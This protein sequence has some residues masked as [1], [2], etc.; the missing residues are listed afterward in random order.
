M[1]LAGVSTQAARAGQ[2]FRIAI[3][4]GVLMKAKVIHLSIG[5]S[6][7]LGIGL[8]TFGLRAQSAIAAK[9][10][11][12]DSRCEVASA[13]VCGSCA[14]SCPPGKAS[15]CVPGQVQ[16]GLCTIAPSCTCR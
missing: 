14:V 10:A 15:A 12:C 6:L 2:S 11:D 8:G 5:V 4:K 9:P 3:R 16:V 7:L 13:S 1:S